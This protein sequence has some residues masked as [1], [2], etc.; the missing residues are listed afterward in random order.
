MLATVAE[1]STSTLAINKI[2]WPEERSQGSGSNLPPGG[3]ATSLGEG[4]PDVPFGLKTGKQALIIAIVICL[5]SCLVSY[6]MARTQ[7]SVGP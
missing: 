7:A 4:R 5:I 6:L 2:E 1:I 3:L